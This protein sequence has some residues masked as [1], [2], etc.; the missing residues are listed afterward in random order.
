[1]KKLRKFVAV[2][3][4]L[5]MSA[6]SSMPAFAAEDVKR[7]VPDLLTTT[8][9]QIESIERIGT[10]EQITQVKDK[11]SGNRSN[12]FSLERVRTVTISV[13]HY[14]QTGHPT[15]CA[16]FTAKQTLA[17]INGTIP[18][19]SSLASAMGA[20]DET[21]YIDIQTLLDVLN[22]RQSHTGYAQVGVYSIDDMLN[23]FYYAIIG[24]YPP[25]PV[26]DTYRH[27]SDFGYDAVHYLNVS[28]IN[29]GTNK[30]FI[31]DPGRSGTAGVKWIANSLMYDVIKDYDNVILC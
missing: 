22:D 21:E 3:L 30:V 17:Y 2:L 29:T 14:A 23:E 16:V 19:T 31:V 9:K 15:W 24:D 8:Q 20:T 5:S 27:V 1:M 7:D 11:L 26:I 10:P 18:S 25:I 12:P 4:A 28:G 13:P 6:V